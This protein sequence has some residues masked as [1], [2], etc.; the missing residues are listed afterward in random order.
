VGSTFAF[1]RV[2]VIDSGGVRE[3]GAPADLFAR[4]DSVFRQLCD[5]EDSVRD[6]LWNA[7]VWRRIRM[8]GGT[9]REEEPAA[10]RMAI[11]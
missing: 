11:R 5:T 7:A 8:E 9:L 10:A 2:L 3:D 4:P 6:T 1:P